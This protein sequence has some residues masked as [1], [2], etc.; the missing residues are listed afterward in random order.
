MIKRLFN[1][2][3][4]RSQPQRRIGLQ[5]SSGW[6]AVGVLSADGQYLIHC[7]LLETEPG[8]EGEA[9]KK[10]VAA[11]RWSGAT[12]MIV[13][14]SADYQA[15]QIDMPGIPEEE[16]TGAAQLRVREL[17]R[18]PSEQAAVA[19]CRLCSDRRPD[20]GS[21]A[22]VGVAEKRRIEELVGMVEASGVRVESVI[23]QE[24]ALSKLAQQTPDPAAGVALLYITENGG[25][26]AITRGDRLYLARRH[27]YGV[28]SLDGSDSLGIEGLS[29]ELQ[30]SLDYYESQLA[31]SAA[32][33]LLV[34]PAQLERDPLLEQLQAN[35]AVPAARLDLI[36]LFEV[37][38]TQELDGDR[39]VAELLA[40]HQG[41]ASLAV[42]AA[43][44]EQLPP[45]GSFYIPPSR[46]IDWLGAAALVSYV[47]TGVVLL[48]VASGIYLY[49]AAQYEQEYARLE[50]E[51]GRLTA[52]V[53]K[54]NEVLEEH[55]P[56]PELVAKHDSLRQ[57]LQ[58]HR[59]FAA[60][61]EAFEVA[62]FDSFAQAMEGL[63]ERHVK[64]VWL[65][66]FEL[67][68]GGMNI[69]GMALQPRLVAKFIDAL[70]EQPAFSGMGV[71]Q[72]EIERRGEGVD[73]QESVDRYAEAVEFHI[74]GRR[75]R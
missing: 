4:R 19:V 34:L 72:L 21:M 20:G 28:T 68:E 41:N 25:L 38:E 13:L 70:A 14:S 6:V 48:S 58:L 53:N 35:L 50:A 49:N 9:L 46:A 18:T 47:G 65:T 23:P 56:D 59:R 52:Q 16:L 66:S 74:V 63:S 45:G 67:G 26:V 62:S 10:L 75:A 31:S 12:A 29:L 69:R 11:N 36:Q 42:A 24:L 51:H 27:S 30:R 71:E 54:L 7:Q 37:D 61:L 64:G 8:D 17:S 57:E 43:L 44:P 60:E 15:Q 22:L 40:E 55:Q 39:G 3:P 32:S 1:F 73:E 5:I 33:Q 2:M